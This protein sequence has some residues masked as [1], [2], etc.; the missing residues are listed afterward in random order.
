MNT[1]AGTGDLVSRCARVLADAEAARRPVEAL[2]Q[3]H[4]GLGVADAYRIQQRNIMRRAG[5]GERIVGHKIGLT[6]PA[7]Q[8]KF[9]V[10]EP[11]FGHLMDTMMLAAG[12]PLDLGGLIDPQIEVEP[13]FVLGKRLMGPHVTPQEVLRATDYVSTCLEVIDSR[14]IGWRIRL[15]DTVADNGSS[16]RVVLGRDRKDPAGLALDDMV[17][18][19]ELDGKVVETGNTRDILGHPA[20]SIAWL[21]NTVFEFGIVFEPGHVVLPGTGTRSVRIAGHR[22]VVGRIMGLG[23]VALELNGSPANGGSE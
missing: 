13:A 18:E 5:L 7:M 12:T 20:K 21:V 17:T 10:N 6:S 22:R 9:G 1:A 15:A 4:P 3:S 11:D 16:A 14:I 23:E 2:T 8:E 19:L